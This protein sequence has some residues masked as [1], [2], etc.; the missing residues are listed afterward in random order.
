MVTS[1]TYTF[2]NPTQIQ[3][4]AFEL[5]RYGS[6]VAIQL[7]VTPASDGMT[8]LITFS[9]PGV[10][11][12]SL[13]DGTYTLI[14]HHNEV[15][16]VSGP[17]MTADDVNTFVRLFGDVDGDGVVTAPDAAELRSAESNPFSPFVPDLD[18]NG[19]GVLDRRDVTQFWRRYGHRVGPAPMPAA[20]PVFGHRPALSRFLLAP[21]HA[22]PLRELGV[23]HTAQLRH[24][25][26][27]PRPI[28]FARRA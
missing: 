26:N 28:H 2:A 17:P 21:P 7:H 23:G 11:G 22:R 9:G 20:R 24:S 25:L 27:H 19:N 4:G 8:Y 18:F 16:V 13:P 1:L 5:L 10:V 3:P 12:G 14:T 15:T 6:P